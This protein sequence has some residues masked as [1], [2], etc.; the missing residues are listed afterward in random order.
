MQGFLIDIF[1]NL[2]AST[3]TT[4]GALAGRRALRKWHRRRGQAES[5]SAR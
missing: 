1:A 4:I 2:A 5:N 3:V